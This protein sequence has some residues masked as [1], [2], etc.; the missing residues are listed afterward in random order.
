MKVYVAAKFNRKD[1]VLALFEKLKGLGHEVSFDWTVHRFIKPYDENVQTAGEYTSEDMQGVRDCDIFILL[2]G[3]EKS[4]G[5]HV[6]LGAAILSS[7]ERGKPIIYVV[8]DCDTKSMFYFH[9]SV[10]RK[11][12]IDEVLEEIRNL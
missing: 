8:G 5:A 3:E 9:P 11:K 10:K 6:E 2:T 4:T 1:E 12:S 7:L